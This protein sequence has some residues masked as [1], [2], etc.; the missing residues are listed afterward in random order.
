MRAPL[1]V[2]AACALAGCA[3][4]QPATDD[5]PTLEPPLAADAE[6]SA[7][8][9]AVPL[10]D[11]ALAPLAPASPRAFVGDDDALIVVPLGP[12][13]PG[14]DDASVA[15]A[16]VARLAREPLPAPDPWIAARAWR[17]A[18]PGEDP[19]A[20]LLL[21]PGA[22]VAGRD[23][24]RVGDAQVALVRAP[25]LPAAAS[26]P[27]PLPAAFARLAPALADASMRWRARLALQRLG[28]DAS[29][30]GAFEDDAVEAFADA[31]ERRARAAIAAIA[32]SDAA[33][34]DRVAGALSR[35]VTFPDGVI[36][37]AWAD[38][39]A[40]L[41]DLFSIALNPA[42]PQASLADRARQWIDAQPRAVAWIADD[43]GLLGTR[44]L[45]A[46]LAGVA[47]LVG[48]RVAPVASCDP[49]T[50]HPLLPRA[51]AEIE[52]KCRAR[53]AQREIK[54]QIADWSRT[55][56]ALAAPAAV[57]PPGVRIGPL[58]LP[59]SMR[60]FLAQQ[61]ALPDAAHAAAALIQRKP[62]SDDWQIYAECLA[63][64]G[65]QPAREGARDTL[66]FFF[67]PRATPR[68][69]L[70]FSPDAQTPG[71]SIRRD[72]D[73]W[74]LF[75]DL[76]PDAFEP[77]GTLLVG[78]ER[79]DARGVRSVWPRPVLPWDDAPSRVAVDPSTW[80]QIRP[81]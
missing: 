72:D 52:L 65:E 45:V 48:A 33:L 60:T 1:L 77:D 5:A 14:F 3:S 47:D 16:R 43:A 51:V 10:D 75:A 80:P 22:S 79:V 36:A 11:A 39:D 28:V 44:V 57:S 4:R 62:A 25:G 67:G 29:S 35:T 59:F 37:P 68:L 70:E 30:L 49:P 38:A 55:L 73:R 41:D 12:T 24:I 13:P 17:A 58:A 56:D 26:D 66:R 7:T 76:P 53:P 81:R 74:V 69:V 63:P 50:L 71:A 32:G 61:V 31:L 2:L 46:E 9:Q 40:N 27:S 21:I 34:A 18:A 8:P 23:A 20:T 15:P 6:P 42:T 64:P 54:V 78:V 19:A